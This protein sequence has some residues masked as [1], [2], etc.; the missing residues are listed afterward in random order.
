MRISY[1]TA[2]TA[3][4]ALAFFVPALALASSMVRVEST[5][6]AGWTMNPLYA[7]NRPG[8]S[9][10]LS[11]AYGAPGGLGAQ[12]LKL[13]TTDGSAKAQLAHPLSEPV[14]LSDVNE[15][16]YYT[17]RSSASTS[18]PKSQLPAINL[19]IDY[20]GAAGGGFATLVYEPVY[21]TG[22]A[23]AIHE[24]TWQ[25]W[26]ATGSAIWWSTR[27]MPGVP[28]AFTSYVSLED[29][30]A[31]N[32]DAVVGSYIINQGSG[33]GGLMAGVDGFNF[34]GTVFNFEPKAL[35]A[36]DKEQCKNYGW[37]DDFV[38]QYKNQGACV[39]SVVAHKD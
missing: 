36:T 13:V 28:N 5:E 30:V 17:Y 21:Q 3:S 24:D 25:Q 8:G 10:E 29:I 32:P 27:S 23:S 31:N 16:S 34:N 14:L 6:S 12:S 26:D 39:S 11:S 1:K 9:V 2:G 35:K 18:T 37:R 15:L 7:E 19:V 33:N 4:L 20:N 38:T 22:G